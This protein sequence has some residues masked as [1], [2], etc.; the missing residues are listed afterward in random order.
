MENNIEKVNLWFIHLHSFQR[1]VKNFQKRQTPVNFL[2]F[3]KKAQKGHI[4]VKT[5]GICY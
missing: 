2:N 3:S 4:A 5:Y 1:I